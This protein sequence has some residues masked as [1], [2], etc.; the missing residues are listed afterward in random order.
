MSFAMELVK[1]YVGND[2]FYFILGGACVGSSLWAYNLFIHNHY[3]FSVV[4]GLNAI[5]LFVKGV[6][7]EKT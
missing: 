5:F 6:F 3:F 4:F 7:N 1:K 2:T